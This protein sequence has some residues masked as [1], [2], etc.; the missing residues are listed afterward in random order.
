[1]LGSFTPE[2]IDCPVSG[3]DEACPIL[4]ILKVLPGTGLNVD[5]I[6]LYGN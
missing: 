2:A 3:C 6:Q 4:A 5:E 1:M